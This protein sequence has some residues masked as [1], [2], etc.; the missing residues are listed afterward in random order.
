M[1]TLTCRVCGRKLTLF[2]IDE[3]KRKGTIRCTGCG[4]KISYDLTQRSIQKSGYWADEV[5]PFDQRVKDR[6]LRQTKRTPP[7]SPR[8]QAENNP[9]Q[10]KT[11]FARFDLKTGSILPDET[12]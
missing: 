11:G 5:T 10:A 8:R 6:L 1:A 7:R 9:F 4:A 3:K 12:K 2:T